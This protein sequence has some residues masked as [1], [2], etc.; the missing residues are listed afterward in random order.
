MSKC[1]RTKR[2]NRAGK[3]SGDSQRYRCMFCQIK[4]TPQPKPWAYPQAMRKKALQLYVDGMNLRR[5][6]RHLGVHHRTDSLWIQAQAD[7]LPD[8]PVPSQVKEAEMD[9]L[10]TFIGE[11]KNQ[12]YV[13]TIV[14]RFTRCYLGFKVVWQETKK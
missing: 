11:K 2:Q 1:H 9:E 10:F 8:P 3:T 12:I 6:A 14:D 4:Y 13:I 7:Q 5:I